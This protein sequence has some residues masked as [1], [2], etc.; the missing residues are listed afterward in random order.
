MRT[1]Q[2]AEKDRVASNETVAAYAAIF[3]LDVNE[4]LITVEV[5]ENSIRGPKL[6]KKSQALTGLLF[7]GGFAI[8]I[9]LTLWLV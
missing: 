1:I 3:E 4:L 7:I 5:Y 6:S 2:R 8:G 9:V